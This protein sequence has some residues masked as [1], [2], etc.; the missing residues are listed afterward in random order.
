MTPVYVWELFGVHL[1]KP[2]GE[3]SRL[4]VCLGGLHGNLVGMCGEATGNTLLGHLVK[5]VLI[6]IQFITGQEVKYQAHQMERTIEVDTK[7]DCN[8]H[9]IMTIRHNRITQ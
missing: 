2:P 8:I 3:K 7:E 5:F 4:L 9:S 1:Q 6:I